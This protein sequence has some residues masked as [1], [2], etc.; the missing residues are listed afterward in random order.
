MESSTKLESQ[1]SSSSAR[2]K[3]SDAFSIVI[4]VYNEEKG[5][6][7]TLELL[8]EQLKLSNCTYEIVVVNDGSKDRT[9]EI[10]RELQELMTFRV[11]EHPRNRGYGAALKTGIRQAKYGAIVIT[12][13]DGTYP[14]ERIPQLVAL[15]ENADMVVGA[16]TGANVVY[17]TIRK[18]PKWFLVR[19]AEWITNSRILDLNS[20]LRVFRKSV[21]ERFFTILPDTFSFTTTIT[22]AMLTNGYLVHYEPIDYFARQGNS[23]IKPI[24]DTLR[25]V[26]L[27]LRVGMYFAPLRVFLP[28]SG[29]FF[30]WF[31]FTLI[32]DLVVY[33]DLT[34]RTILLLIATTQTGMFALLADMIDK[35]T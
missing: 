6:T 25:F 26:Q 24:R 4:P 20:G 31:L 30:L 33:Q 13:G 14:N 11:I 9:G 16:R 34:E 22:L 8:Q 21:V 23:K 19:F 32:Q 29:F 3:I 10:L 17:P 2:K 35:R 12:D 28:I 27:I 1:L 5:I 15:L 7:P 18:I